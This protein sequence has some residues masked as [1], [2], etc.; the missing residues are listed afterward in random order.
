[1]NYY[2]YEIIREPDLAHYGVPGMKWGVRRY[3]D[4]NGNLT[5]KGQKRYSEKNTI[6]N[7]NKLSKDMSKTRYRQALVQNKLS[8]AIERGNTKKTA[9]YRD[10]NKTLSKSLST[11]ERQ[12][13]KLLNNAKK[14]GIN[15][16]TTEHKRYV[17]A[18]KRIAQYLLFTPA[19]TIGTVKDVYRGYKYGAESAGVVKTKRYRA[20]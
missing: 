8:K 15:V 17:N 4:T 1:M 13:E 19:A 18:G 11:G 14:S 12:T 16:N 2:G 6:R 10:L 7:L 20:S 5:A 9:K 3:V